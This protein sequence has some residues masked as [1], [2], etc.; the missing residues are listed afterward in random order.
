MWSEG[1]L[2]HADDA[3]LISKSA[4]D[5][6]RMMAVIVA[7]SEANSLTMPKKTHTMHRAPD[8]VRQGPQK[9]TLRRYRD[10]YPQTQIVP[11]WGSYSGQLISG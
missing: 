3:G 7:V 6:V 10:D 4:E 9:G 11:M 5:V 1:S 8:D 2:G